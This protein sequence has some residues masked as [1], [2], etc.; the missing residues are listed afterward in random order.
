MCLCGYVCFRALPLALFLLFG[1]YLSLFYLFNTLDACLG[2]DDKK[3]RSGCLGNGGGVM[4]GDIGKEMIIRIHCTKI[5][6]NKK[7]SK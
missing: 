4:R 1:F 3:Y 2:P 6:F 5:Y 7:R